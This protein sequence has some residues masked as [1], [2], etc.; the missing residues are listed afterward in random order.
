MGVDVHNRR[1]PN[2][3]LPADGTVTADGGWTCGPSSGS[4]SWAA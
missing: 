1:R 2:E 3:L 4:A